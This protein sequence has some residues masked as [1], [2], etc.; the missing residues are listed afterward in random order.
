MS[1]KSKIKYLFIIPIFLIGGILG[2][3]LK[4]FLVGYFK[5]K[6]EVD[7]FDILSLAV[8]VVFGIITIIFGYIIQKLLQQRT[9]KNADLRHEHNIIV[10]NITKIIDATVPL[11][12]SF[13]NFYQ[14][15]E[16]SEEDFKKI[17]ADLE[18][19]SNNITTL[20]QILNHCIK[21]EDAEAILKPIGD[22]ERS[23][24]ITL[25]YYY[26]E[27]FKAEDEVVFKDDINNVRSYLQK[28]SINIV[29]NKYNHIIE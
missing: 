3:F 1:K 16:P 12:D 18:T 27:P 28:V 26:P 19:F 8:T 7:V 10:N 25:T 14:K 22:L 15:V 5:F 11:S 24:R 13:Y 23:I 17:R 6:N 2:F 9:E 29:R 4:S 20:E 21:K